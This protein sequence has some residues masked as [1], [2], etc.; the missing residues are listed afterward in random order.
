MEPIVDHR[1]LIDALGGNKALADAIDGCTA[2]RVGQWKITNRIPVEYWPAVIAIA[3]G[4]G[5]EA[6][7]SDWLM[8]SIRPR[9]EYGAA[10]EAVATTST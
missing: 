8:N 10:G 7:D 2:V 9:A 3:S 1:T 5:F 6:I 4:K